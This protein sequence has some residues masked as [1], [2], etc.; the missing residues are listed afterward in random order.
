MNNKIR[1][2]KSD[3]FHPSFYTI[4]NQL[5]LKIVAM[6]YFI[7]YRYHSSVNMDNSLPV[8]NCN[9]PTGIPIPKAP[10]SP[11]PKIRPPSVTT[12]ALTCCSVQLH[13]ISYI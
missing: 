7:E 2:I 10:K 1:D 8:Y 5:K 11:K 9:F 6:D 13:K 12:I 4:T 3:L